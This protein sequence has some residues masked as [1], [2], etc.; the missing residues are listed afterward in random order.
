MTACGACGGISLDRLRVREMMFGT[1]EVFTYGECA[2]CGS[3][4][5]LDPPEDLSRFYDHDTY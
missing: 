4:T 2:N 1:R 3:L 5:L